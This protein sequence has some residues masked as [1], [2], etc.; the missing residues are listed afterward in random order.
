MR[1]ECL[2]NPINHRQGKAHG[3]ESVASSPR[4]RTSGPSHTKV[5]IKSYGTALVKPPIGIVLEVTAHA[6]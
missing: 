5:W 3:R 2:E 6:I 4:S 1:E